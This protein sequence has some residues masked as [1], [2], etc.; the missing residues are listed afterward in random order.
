MS[1][2]DEAER[3]RGDL[4]RAH[5]GGKFDEGNYR[6]GRRPPRCGRQ[7][8]QR[9]VEGTGGLRQAGRSRCGSSATGQGKP[10]RPRQEGR[11][12]SRHRHHGVLPPRPHHLPRI[13]FDAA[14]IR[15]R[16]EVA[17]YLHKGVKITFENEVRRRRRSS[18]STRRAWRPI[19]ASSSASAGR[20]PCTTPRSS[21][22]RTTA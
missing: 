7:R 2:E 20:A 8:R 3:A 16:L 22:R 4:H 11:P 21:L 6:D 1:P 12:G 15:E 17:S 19:W 10:Q 5:A 13:E 9:A 18:S 14:V